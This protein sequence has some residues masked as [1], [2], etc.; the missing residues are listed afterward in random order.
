[1]RF[2]LLR[3][4]FLH[5]LLPLV[6]VSGSG[7]YGS[8]IVQESFQTPAGGI[9]DAW[10][11]QEDAKNGQGLSRGI[12]KWDRPGTPS[13]GLLVRR[14]AAGQNRFNLIHTKSTPLAAVRGSVLLQAAGSSSMAGVFLRADRTS[15]VNT[16]GYFI[17][18]RDGKT[19]FIAKNPAGNHI[20]PGEILAEA[21]LNA[22]GQE[23]IYKLEFEAVDERLTARA[24]AWDI[25]L[26]QW[27]EAAAVQVNDG[28]YRSGRV[29]LRASFGAD[30][31][32]ARFAD[33]EISILQ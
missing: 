17:G 7:A 22:F 6:L 12:Q 30:K 15:R 29:G 24:Q 4:L 8:V 32:T 18:I 28:E 3:P 9:P 5:V 26:E 10:S 11:L 23:T 33:F 21:P 14:D 27:T 31:R 2:P 20:S 16:N 19:L 25:L 13:M 1:M